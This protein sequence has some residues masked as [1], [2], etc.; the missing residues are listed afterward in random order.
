MRRALAVG[1][2]LFLL[3]ATGQSANQLLSKQDVIDNVNAS[4]FTWSSGQPAGWAGSNQ[5]VTRAD[6]VSALAN[7]GSCAGSATRALTFSEI[8]ACKNTATVIAASTDPWLING[9]TSWPNHAGTAIFTALPEGTETGPAG[10]Q[11]ITSS[12]SSTIW[13]Q[14]SP[15]TIPSGNV[16]QVWVDTKSTSVSRTYLEDP[17]CSTY[18][19]GTSTANASVTLSIYSSGGTVLASVTNSDYDNTWKRPHASFTTTSS[20]TYYF[21]VTVNYNAGPTI[22]YETYNS[23]TMVCT[24]HVGAAATTS[25]EATY[26]NTHNPI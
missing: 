14:Y 8:S 2:L 19:G 1:L 10:A 9:N 16:L 12:S 6:I 17:N 25:S 3:G 13:Q 15:T 22:D 20:G 5:I 4:V 26:V 21:G 11:Y 24:H 7:N 23:G 18:S